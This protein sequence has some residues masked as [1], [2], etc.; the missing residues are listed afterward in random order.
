MLRALNSRNY[1]LYFMGQILS[2]IGTWMQQVAM[3]WLVYRLTN[4][5][6]L[7]GIVGFASQISSL[8][9][10]PFTG[11]ASDRFSRKN[12][13]IVTQFLFM[14]QSLLL[15]F[16][17]LTDHIDISWILILAFFAGT[18][19]AFDAPAR[20]SFVIQIVDNRD[21]VS[22]AIALNSALFHGSRLIGPAVAGLIVA[23]WGEGICFLINGVSYVT[24]ILALFFI[25][26]SPQKYDRGSGLFSSFAESVKYAA[27]SLPIRSILYIVAFASFVGMPY[28]IMLPVVARDILRGDA[29]TL[30]YLMSGA[31]LGALCGALNLG[32]LRGLRRMLFNLAR[33]P[34]M[35]GIAT[36]LFA[37]SNNLLLSAGFLVFSGFGMMSIMAS[38]N[39]IL[40]QVVDDRIRG[41]VLSL[42]TISF[43][44]VVPLGS[45]VAGSLAAHIGVPYTVAL[46]GA[47]CV[48]ASAVFFLNFGRIYKA[49]SRAAARNRYCFRQSHPDHL[50]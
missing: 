24:I 49:V 30:G 18:I 20:H 7:L 33:G 29:M 27:N 40:Q 32:S 37:F 46:M 25:N 2:L 13:L 45:L 42:Y 44:G 12:I 6:F 17:V 23:I 26:A 48:C 28:T 11:V 22:S 41:R 50:I 1:R 19:M 38:S 10:A 34:L 39:T 21:D 31:G 8:F 36:F 4:S 16:L 5:P 15:A 3:G 14:T 43:F 47:L 35:F 9:L